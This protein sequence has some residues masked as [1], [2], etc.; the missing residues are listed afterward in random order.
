MRVLLGVWCLG[1][2]IRRTP[3]R[4]TLSGM[5]THHITFRARPAPR[6]LLQAA[7]YLRMLTTSS[8]VPLLIDSGTGTRTRVTDFAEE[9]KLRPPQPPRPRHLR[10]ARAMKTMWPLKTAPY[11]AS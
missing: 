11:Y 4:L 8:S 9:C 2:R 5:M 10:G 3:E 7:A 6:P 1:Y